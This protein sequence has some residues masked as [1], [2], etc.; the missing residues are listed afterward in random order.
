MRNT[1]FV[2]PKERR[3]FRLSFVG[4]WGEYYLKDDLKPLIYQDNNL[5]KF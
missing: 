2:L 3:F 4:T 5:P 1:P